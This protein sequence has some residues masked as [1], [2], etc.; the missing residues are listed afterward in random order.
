MIQ[1]SM[2]LSPMK[3]F[4][5]LDPPPPQVKANHTVG[6]RNGRMVKA[7]ATKAYR[8]HAEAQAIAAITAA[9]WQTVQSATVEIAGYFKTVAFPDKDNLLFSL[10]A[11]FDGF[12]DAR[13]WTD[14]KDATYLPPTRTKDAER[15]RIELI[16]HAEEPAILRE[17]GE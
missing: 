1:P 17:G 4:I 5:T 9:G 16:I 15:P 11:A 12:T 6:S 13:V 14:D 3:L 8:Q 7:M 2:I 10:K